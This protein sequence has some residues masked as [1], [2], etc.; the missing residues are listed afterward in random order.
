MLDKLR[1]II[2]LNFA[3]M[4]NPVNWVII[5]LM[6]FIAGIAISFIFQNSTSEEN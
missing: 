1:S 5:T 2:P 4:N 6:I 3:L